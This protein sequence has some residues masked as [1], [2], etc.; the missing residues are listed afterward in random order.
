MEIND[1]GN[2]VIGAVVTE[3]IVEGRFGLLTSHSW[4]RDYGSQTDLPGVKLPA[5]ATDAA[6]AR[7]LVAFEQDN[8]SLPI[9]QPNPSFSN[10][11]RYGFDQAS[12]APFSAQVF[13]A[14]PNVQDGSLTIPS[15]SNA[16]LHG[17]GIFTVPSGQYIY[18][19]SLTTPGATLT[20]ANTADDGGAT[21]AGKLKYATSAI[22]AEVVKYNSTTGALTF[23]IL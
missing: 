1:F 20:V 5:N 14:H 4:S 19:A 16:V 7:Y 17:D 18:N 9:Y 15:G 21:E 22:L 10:A 8:R 23:R 3:D 13:L 2:V 11:L 6:K 12:N